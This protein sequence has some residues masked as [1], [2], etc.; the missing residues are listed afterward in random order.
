MTISLSNI[1]KVH[2]IGIGGIGISALAQFLLTRGKKVSAND[3]DEFPMV[4]L[5]RKKGIVTMLGSN[6]EVI[7]KDTE[8][9]IYS[10]AWTTLGPELIE[11]AKTLGVPVLSYPEMLA[12]IS[13]ELRT[14]AISGSHGKTTTTAMVAH[15]CIGAQLDPT[16]IVGSVMKETGSNFRAGKS[17]FLVVEA[18]EY[19]RAF[20]NLTPEMLVIVNID[21]DHLDYYRD[22]ADIKSAYRELIQRMPPNGVVIYDG[23]NQHVVDVVSGASQR[24]VNY[25]EFLR[26]RNLRQF[27]NHNQLNAAAACAVA[28]ELGI[29]PETYDR[30]VTTFPGT[31]RRLEEKGVL[32]NGARII[33]DYAHH[34]VEVA[35]A[36][37]ALREEFPLGTCR[38]VV[39]FQ[40]HLYSRTRTLWDGFVS[41]FDGAD[42]VRLLPI[43]PAR[44]APEEGITSEQLA[45]AMSIHRRDNVVAFGSFEEAKEELLKMKLGP[46][47][48]I[49][50][51]G[52]GEAFKVG[53][54]LL[55]EAR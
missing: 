2:I 54:L 46:K 33:D 24:K 39:L 48:V 41:A 12:V 32:E 11:Y 13:K 37:A 21:L 44:E 26:H 30:L 17:N 53:D 50:T 49:V 35:A 25:H 51:M 38:V 40:P 19:R 29:S 4:S 8:L 52:A 55:K 36:L 14:I 3:L 34:P 27:G 1:H 47:D 18:D 15:M 22:I 45:K 16:V 10:N 6:T 20:L 31:A 28:Q 43:Y 9:V 23:D 42:I 7:P 5:L